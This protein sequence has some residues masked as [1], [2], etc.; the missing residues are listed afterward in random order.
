[1]R[2]TGCAAAGAVSGAGAG[3]RGRTGQPG[4]QQRNR[5]RTCPCSG[6]RASPGWGPAAAR[7]DHPRRPRSL[8][9]PPPGS[10]WV[11]SRC[12]S[13]WCPPTP[14]SPPW[15]PLPRAK[16]RACR[17][18][19]APRRACGWAA[20][21]NWAAAGG[22]G[23]QRAAGA[24]RPPSRADRDH[25]HGPALPA[26]R[27]ADAYLPAVLE[28]GTFYL[29]DDPQELA[30]TVATE[31]RVLQRNWR[32]QRLPLLLV[33][34]A[35][36]P[37]P[38]RPG[39][40]PAAGPRAQR[41]ARGVP[42]Q[43]VPWSELE[44]QPGGA[45]RRSPQALAACDRVPD[46][47]RRCGPAPATSPSPP[48]RNRNWR[49]QQADLQPGGAALGQHLPGGAAEVLEQLVRRLGN[50]TRAAGAPQRSRRATDRAGGG[51]VPT[52]P[53]RGQ[54]E[55]GAPVRRRH[56]AGAP[57]AGGCPH[58]PAGAAEATGGGPQLHPRLPDHR[59]GQQPGDRR[60]SAASAARTAANGCCSRNC[61]WPSTRWH[62][63]MPNLLSGSLTLQLG[64]LLLLLTGELAAEADLSPSDAFEALCSLPP[65]AYVAGCGTC[66]PMWSTP[67]PP[68]NAR[69]SCIVRGPGALGGAR[70][71]GGTAE[72]RE[73]VAAPPAAG[74]AA[75]GA[76]ASSMPASGICS[77]TA[78]AW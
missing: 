27:R 23:R 37:L 14:R 15:R 42:V 46:G 12:W 21:G 49:M 18:P 78:G 57:P 48:S 28:E 53:G 45:P 47:H 36:V 67:A 26:G 6:P 8:R 11:P 20:P 24:E 66:W 33:P 40:L 69:N 63:R 64:Q 56:G 55:C 72:G 73:L 71:A 29:A 3:D 58:R 61:C 68:C 39:G 62:A 30:D 76:A 31:L 51:G 70:S 44:A 7:A 35:A 52:C 60:W 59:T 17:S 10:R 1:M 41:G 4:S 77:T 2:W 13:A 9:P 38:S 19:A 54:L 74:G 22:G 65:H 50:P 43:L 75:A 16:P 25:G 32:G 34:V 5:T